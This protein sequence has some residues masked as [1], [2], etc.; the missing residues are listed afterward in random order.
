LLR[1]RAVTVRERFLRHAASRR[2]PQR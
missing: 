1:I 2:F